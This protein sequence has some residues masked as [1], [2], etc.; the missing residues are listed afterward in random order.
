MVRFNGVV[1]FLQKF[2]RSVIQQTDLI[3]EA[4]KTIRGMGEKD[5]RLSFGQKAIH[6]I[7]TLFL[8]SLIVG[9]KDLIDKKQIRLQVHRQG[10]PE[11]TVHPRRINLEGEIYEA[12]QFGK[13]KDVGI[14]LA[15]LLRLNLWMEALR[16]I[17]SLEKVASKLP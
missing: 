2:D 5:D 3:T 12:V 4:I 11:S 1:R 15:N 8:E 10:K 7:D 13:A 9:S 16:K 6:L 17:F 14:D